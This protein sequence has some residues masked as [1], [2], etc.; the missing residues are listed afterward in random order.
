MSDS[1]SRDSFYDDDSYDDIGSER[2]SEIYD[3]D[4]ESSVERMG[5]PPSVPP[6]EMK[7]RKEDFKKP[8]LL[9]CVSKCILPWAVDMRVLNTENG[10]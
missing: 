8:N 10:K 9:H 6:S 7:L 2:L 4:S 5:P 3:R 1:E